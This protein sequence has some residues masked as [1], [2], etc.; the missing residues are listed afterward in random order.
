LRRTWAAPRC[1]SLV[2][3]LRAV[4]ARGLSGLRARWRPFATDGEVRRDPGALELLRWIVPQATAKMMRRLRGSADLTIEWRIAVRRGGDI[5]AAGA[6]ADMSGFHFLDAPRGHFYADPFPAVHERVV[7]LFFEQYDFASQKAV[8]ACGRLTDDNRLEDVQVILD[9][10][11]HLSYPLVFEHDGRWWLLPESKANGTVDLYAADAF[12]YKW[13]FAKTLFRGNAA[14]TSVW[15]Q[16][17]LL[18]FFATLV[19]PGGRGMSLRLYSTA[20]LAGEWQPHPANPITRDVRNARGAGAIFRRH[21]RLY[22]PSQDCA[23]DYGAAF[24][25]NEIVA[26]TPDRYEEKPVL[27][28]TPHWDPELRG[29]HTYNRAGDLEVIDASRLVRRSRHHP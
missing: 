8:L 14:D 12:P 9:R 11:Y 4:H 6:E 16:D 27:A 24:A 13:R 29:T 20:S 22:R 2:E 5:L 15:F 28:V 19:D 1:S 10:P 21:G 3:T 18:W 25:L 7:W 26:L 23:W 17:G